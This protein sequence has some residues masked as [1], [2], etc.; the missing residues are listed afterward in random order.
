MK[1]YIITGSSS[2]IGKECALL[3]AQRNTTLHLIA[4]RNQENF[5]N[6]LQEKG[7]NVFV[8]SFDLSKTNQIEPLISRV[9]QQYIDFNSA[10]AIYLINNA[11]LLTPIGPIGKYSATD[12]RESIEVNFVAPSIICHEFIKHTQTFKGTKRILNISSGAALYPYYGWSHYCSS[13][14]GLEMLTRC[15]ALEH[16]QHV[17][18]ASY[19]PGKTDTCMQNTIRNAAKDDFK[20]VAYFIDAYEENQLNSPNKVANHISKILHSENYPNGEHVKFNV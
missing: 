14:A 10:E 8:Y 1:H 19:N 11:G 17:G 16:G 6:V 18:C 2:G 15:I 20:D 3:L 5:K 13:K 7:A 12:Y 4:R 9:I